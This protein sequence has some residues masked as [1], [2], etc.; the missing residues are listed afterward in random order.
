ME[1]QRRRKTITR[2]AIAIAV[3]SLLVTGTFFTGIISSPVTAALIFLAVGFC[4]A[5]T[6]FKLWRCPSCKAHLGRLYIGVSG[7]KFC[8]QCGIRL[9]PDR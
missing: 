8:P 5:Y 7:P 9:A 2:L 3:L 6:N 4:A 1:F